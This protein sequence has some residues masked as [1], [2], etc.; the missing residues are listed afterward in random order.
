MSGFREL[1]ATLSR[2]QEDMVKV[3][4]GGAT[5]TPQDIVRATWQDMKMA[6]NRRRP[7]QHGVP[8][9]ESM[10]EMV[11]RQQSV[12][13]LK[14]LTGQLKLNCEFVPESYSMPSQVQHH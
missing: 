11:Y 9:A 12:T 3:F 10:I 8:W 2:S 6:I 7:Q 14:S 4:F 5:M 13:I 1:A